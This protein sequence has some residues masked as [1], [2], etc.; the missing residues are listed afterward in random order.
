MMEQATFVSLGGG[1][2]VSADSC[3]HAAPHSNKVGDVVGP[4]TCRD[5]RMAELGWTWGELEERR[6]SRNEREN[7]QK[8]CGVK[9]GCKVYGWWVHCAAE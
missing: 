8:G 7:G 1:G 5:A 9:R 6:R 2:F 3:A 4:P